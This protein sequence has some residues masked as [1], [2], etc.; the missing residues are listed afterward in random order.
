MD[1]LTRHES[2]VKEPITQALVVARW[3]EYG[4]LAFQGLTHVLGVFM[5]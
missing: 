5:P 3:S 2:G 4:H 1:E